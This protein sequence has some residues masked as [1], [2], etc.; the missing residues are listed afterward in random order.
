M[1]L[2]LLLIS[3]LF[4]AA[5]MAA[6]PQKFLE[7][8]PRTVFVQLFEWPWKDIARECEVYLGPNGFS[9]VQVS[10]PNE[11]LIQ[12]EATW[13]ERYQVVSYIIDSRSGNEAEFTDM[14]RRCQKAGVD[15]YVDALLNHMTGYASGVGY[16]GSS[17]THYN[18]PGIYNSSDFHHCGR[19]GDNSI[20]N[21]NDLYELLN[22]DLVGLAD[23]ATEDNYVQQRLADYLNHLLSLGVA[24]FRLDAAKHMPARDIRNILNRLKKPAYVL[25]ELIVSPGE[26]VHTSD[27]LSN[28]DVMAYSYPFAVGTAF[29]DKKAWKLFQLEYGMPAS[30]DSVVFIDNHDLQ[31]QN[32]VSLLNVQENSILY[33]LGQ[34]FLLAWPYGYPHLFSGYEFAD[35]DQ[36]PP[37]DAQLKTL[38]VLDRNDQCLKPWI[39]AHHYLEV[40]PMVDFRNQTDNNFYATDTWTNNFDQLAFG[41]GDAGFVVINYSTLSL[42]RSFKTSLPAGDYCNIVSLDYD[43][44]K[45]TCKQGLKVDTKGFVNIGLSPMSAAV[46]LKQATVK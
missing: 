45:R 44:K 41:R 38:P 34:I 23:L 17:F 35:Y 4:S 13:W 20:K 43:K 29:T 7:A 1:K 27:Y 8:S 21:Y 14:L 16:A 30:N 26:P 15:V 24:G 42:S 11:H 12:P 31:R 2:L 10:P 9:A 32:H 18:Y 25:Q 3:S 37:V 36:G 28:G 19:N 33:R 39:C 22:C 40:L 6:R 5:A 46:L